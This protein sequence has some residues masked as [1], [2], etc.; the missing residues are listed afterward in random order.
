MTESEAASAPTPAASSPPAKG[1]RLRRALAVLALIPVGLGLWLVPA[2]NAGL[3]PCMVKTRAVEAP[4]DWQ[5]VEAEATKTLAGLL[6]IPSI[7]PPGNELP[8]AQYLAAILE[9]EGIPHELV[10]TH[11]G[12]ALVAA[13]IKG[14]SSEGALGLVNHIDV[15]PAA[16]KSW[17]APD[18]PFSGRIIDGRIYG[19][20][21]LDM[22]GFAVMQL[23]TLLL[24]KRHNIPL[25]RDLVYLALPD[26]EGGGEA[27]AQWV[28]KNRP[29]LFKGV[30]AMWNEGGLGIR[31]MNGVERPVF[32]LM[33]AERGG[34]WIR[35]EATGPGGHG[36]TA[37]AGNAPDQLY[38]AVTRIL[39]E[40]DGL[41]LTEITRRQFAEMAN[42]TGALPGF[43]LRRADHPLVK[44]LLDPKFR[45]DRFLK[46]VTR[47]TRTLTVMHFGQKVNVV[48]PV[49]EARIDIRL[50]PGYEPETVL[51]GLRELC[52]DLSVTIEIIHA[53]AASQSPVGTPLFETIR[54]TLNR[55]HPEAVVVPLLSPGGT[56]SAFF[57]PLGIDCYG[58]IPAL[59][60]KEELTG[61]HGKDEHI[62]V[63]ALREGTRVTFEATVNA[64]QA[65]R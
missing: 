44:P 37:P 57:R 8:A 25:E 51:A 38:Q 21:A 30:T 27:G 64:L 24:I 49:A 63:S 20:G 34:L 41:E 28:V 17:L 26:E 12:R 1:S 42:A 29:D 60:E 4:V 36:S 5:A 15:V 40:T 33:H 14:K 65:T 9:R 59:F 13:R 56:D 31:K 52:K 10:E 55:L 7:N 11:P 48:P 3:P 58:L 32:G 43:F 39:S 61:F 45:K 19:R 35:L 46:A 6:A 53:K 23:M 18:L 16:P 50:L 54:S 47:N 22:K 2:G 62:R